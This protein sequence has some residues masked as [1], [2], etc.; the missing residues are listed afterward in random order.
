MDFNTAI[1]YVCGL[2]VAA[3]IL[4]LLI[5]YRGDFEAGGQAGSASL[6]VKAKQ[7]RPGAR[8]DGR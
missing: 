2:I 6:F 5:K 3:Y 1:V 8:A 4:T 7:R